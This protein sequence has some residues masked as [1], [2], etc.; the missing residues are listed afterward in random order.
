[1]LLRLEAQEL[2]R[3]HNPE[4]LSIKPGKSILRFPYPSIQPE[5]LQTQPRHEPEPLREAWELYKVFDSQEDLSES[6]D[7]T[8]Y[9]LTSGVDLD[10]R[11]TAAALLLA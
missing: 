7:E 3:N 5:N 4:F 6:E 8:G 9:E 10:H 11:G 2:F 1:M